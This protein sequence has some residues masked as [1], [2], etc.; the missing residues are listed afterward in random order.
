MQ[1][2]VDSW[3]AEHKDYRTETRPTIGPAFRELNRLVQEEPF[4]ALIVIDAIV[5]KNNSDPI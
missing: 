1:Q 3:I 2:L 4:A 5:T